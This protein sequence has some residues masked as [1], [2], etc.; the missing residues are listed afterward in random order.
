MKVHLKEPDGP[1]SC[2]LDTGVMTVTL[3]DVFL[4]VTFETDGGEKLSVC[5]RDSGFEI[6]YTGDFGEK[7]FDAGWFEFKNSR[8][9]S[10]GSVAKEVQPSESSS[11]VPG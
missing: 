1:Y 11:S 7:G 10:M 6:H 9:N 4:G 5:M 2:E 3:K 8:V